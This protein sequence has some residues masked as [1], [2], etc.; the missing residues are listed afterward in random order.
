MVA[1]AVQEPVQTVQNYVG[2]Q[3]RNDTALGHP[4]LGWLN[5]A[6]DLHSRFQKKAG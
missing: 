6:I 3:W 1:L 2:Q 4:F 5:N